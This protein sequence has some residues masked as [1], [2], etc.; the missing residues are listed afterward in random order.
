MLAI[1]PRCGGRYTKREDSEPG[2]GANQTFTSFFQRMEIGERLVC[3]QFSVRGLCRRLRR[4]PGARAS[5][6]KALA[7]L[8]RNLHYPLGVSR[9]FYFLGTAQMR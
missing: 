8:G 5:Y 7:W 1:F 3:P 9:A 4:I 6:G 2:K